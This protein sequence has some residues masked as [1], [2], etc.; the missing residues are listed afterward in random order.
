[1][2][3]KHTLV[4]IATVAGFAASGQT[5]YN[6]GAQVA[7]M[8]GAKMM[9][10]ATG[11]GVNN[12]SLENT[13]SGLFKN[14]GDVY[15][16]GSFVNTNGTA[17]GYAANTGKYIVQKDWINDDAF[18]ADQSKVYLTGAGQQIGGTSVTTFYDLYCENALTVKSMSIDANVQNVL[19]LDT[20]ELATNNYKLTILNP[21]SGAI[22]THGGDSAFVSSTNVGRLVR[23][24]NS[25]DSYLF[26]TGWNN[27]GTRVKRE[28]Q[29][30]P[31][32]SAARN[33][34]V[35][36]AFNTGSITTTTDDGFNVQSVATNVEQANNKFYH[37]IASS[38]NTPAILGIYFNPMQDQNVWTSIG[39]WQDTP[40]WTDLGS[41][42]IATSSPRAVAVRPNWSDNGNAPHALVKHRNGDVIDYAFPNAFAPASTDGS[43]PPENT[44]FTII[45]RNGSVVLDELMVFN[46]WGEMVYNS[47]R[48]GTDVWDGYFQGKLQEQGNYTFLAKM[49]RASDGKAIPPVSGN[50]TLIW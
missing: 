40:H 46:R 15:I 19:T 5:F 20:T 23:H 2:N 17:D 10:T 41:T 29:I 14:K 27:G 1:M 47:K 39:R 32:N 50:L 16:Q 13:A 18:N 49:R 28:V 25:T 22:V 3:V 34:A 24:T 37:L 7:V 42:T 12:G 8:A 30:A 35:R 6:N 43:V 45:N 9:I 44:V 33:Y 26:P 11:S 21:S 31:N 4:I 38:D 36:F 48:D